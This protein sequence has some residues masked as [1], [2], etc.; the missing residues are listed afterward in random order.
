MKN[1]TISFGKRAKTEKESRNIPQ[2]SRRRSS[3]EKVAD[4]LIGR[5]DE[6]GHRTVV[7]DNKI[8]SPGFFIDRHLRI[9]FSQSVS[10]RSGTYV[11]T[12]GCGGASGGTSA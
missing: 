4:H 10:K 8:R 5:L 6:F 2:L 1:G 12:A 9:D 11:S 7:A 3:M